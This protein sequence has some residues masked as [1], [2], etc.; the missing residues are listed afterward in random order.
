MDPQPK[1]YV[2]NL[3]GQLNERIIACSRCPRLISYC[4]NIGLTKRK[5]FLTDEYWAKPVPNF[6]DPEATRLII[7]L[8]PAAH[9]ANRTG[10]M[11][12]GDRS[13]DFLFE[14]LHKAGLCNQPT[15]ICSSDGLQ[16]AGVLIT[17]CVHCAPPDN[18]PSTKEI[19]NCRS[20]FLELFH[21]RDWASILCLG[22]LAWTQTLTLLKDS[23]QI[24]AIQ[25]FGHGTCVVTSSNL[26]IVGSYHPSQQNTFTGKLTMPMML[27]AI[28][29]F[30]MD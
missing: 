9:G 25:K 19:S 15:S 4:Q 6:G 27:E 5:A 22:T 11:F 30:A 17:A 2:N 13:G 12:T 28:R 3:C 14:A 29:L 16:L 20:Y 7:G 24:K 18:K 10:R 8:A 21:S 26:K 1:I 23:G